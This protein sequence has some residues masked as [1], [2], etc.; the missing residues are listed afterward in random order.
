MT[1][2]TYRDRSCTRDLMIR[3]MTLLCVPVAAVL[4]CA[5]PEFPEEPVNDPTVIGLEAEA[6]RAALDSIFWYTGFRPDSIIVGEGVLR[7]TMPPESVGQTVV[8]TGK[9][10][11]SPAIPYGAARHLAQTA[12]RQVGR[13]V[14]ADTVVLSFG[15]LE[16]K[17]KTPGG[18]A[19]CSS[20]PA[21]MRLE[22][23]DLVTG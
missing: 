3:M 11:S 22:P 23:R 14:E 18:R 1:T 10:C 17:A 13:S 15:K 12:W 5:V 4:G 8:A 16:V 7:L 20:G 2:E 21:T 6:G 9:A 19:S